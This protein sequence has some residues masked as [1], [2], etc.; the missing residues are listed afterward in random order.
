MPNAKQRL[1]SSAIFTDRTD[2]GKRLAEKL[3]QYRG[4]DAV[5]LA[6]PRGGVVVG[7]ELARALKLPLDI[8]V[9]RKIGHPGD[10]E[11]AICAVDEHGELL[12]NEMEK[13]SVDESWLNEEVGRQRKEAQRRTETYRG[14]RGPEKIAGK[15][16]ILV[17]DGIAT[18]LTM[19][20]AVAVVAKQNPQKIIV[21]VPVAP[22]NVILKIEKEAEV[23]TLLPPDEFMGAVGAH[24]EQFEQVEDEK[25]IQLMQKAKINAH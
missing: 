18:G 19:R 13:R 20:L 25:V 9:T 1:V 12:C 17:D 21:A 7:Y 16:A 2:A 15:I 22:A 14:G 3:E 4:K 24:Y 11:Y 5:V 23:V 10:P 8:V 6:L